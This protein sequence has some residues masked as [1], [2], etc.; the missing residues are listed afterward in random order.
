MQDMKGI[1]WAYFERLNESDYQGAAAT[2]ADDG[3]WWTCLSR[4]E[5]TMAEHKAL[6]PAALSAVPMRFVLHNAYAE[7]DTVILEAESHADL[8]DGRL[9]NNLY[10]YIVTIRDGLISAV[11]EYSDTKHV[12]DM[13]DTLM[14]LYAPVDAGKAE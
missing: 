3:V 6:F 13:S 11:R 8:P 1:A 14:S 4:T 10:V 7:G 9:Y 5:T 2:L 12:A